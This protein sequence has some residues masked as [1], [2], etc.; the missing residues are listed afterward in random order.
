MSLTQIQKLQ[1]NTVKLE[2]IINSVLHAT[3]AKYPNYCPNF[4]LPSS[5]TVQKHSKTFQWC[6]KNA[7]MQGNK[8]V[9]NIADI[10]GEIDKELLL[11]KEEVVDKYCKALGVEYMLVGA[12]DEKNSIS[13]KVMELLG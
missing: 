2:E 13:K 8:A 1:Q 3:H 6:F 4:L 12:Y 11:F 9:I 7:Y 5:Y 10:N